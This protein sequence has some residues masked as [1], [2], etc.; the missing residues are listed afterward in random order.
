MVLLKALNKDQIINDITTSDVSLS[1][2]G[3]MT[4]LQIYLK[5]IYNIL[6]VYL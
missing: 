1:K 6:N 3:K 2:L 4:T 5:M